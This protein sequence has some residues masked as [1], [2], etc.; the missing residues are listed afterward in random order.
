MIEKLNLLQKRDFSGVINAAFAFLSQEFKAYG[1]MFALFTGVPLLLMAGVTVWFINMMPQDMSAGEVPGAGFWWAFVF[2]GVLSFF[3][4]ALLFGTTGAYMSL[5]VQ[6]GAGNFQRRDV[7]SHFLQNL[8][9]MLGVLLLGGALFF[10]IALV[11]GVVVGFL[12]S[13]DALPWYI[14]V[15]LV[16]L[17]IGLMI[18]A[19]VPLSM[20]HMVVFH[21]KL[22][23]FQALARVFTLVRGAWW[24]TFGVLFVLSIIYSMLGFIFSIPTMAYPVIQELSGAGM[25]EPASFA[26]IALTVFSVLGRFVLYPILL[27]GVGVQYFSL[28]AGSDNDDLLRK[29]EAIG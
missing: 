1:A 10:A 28:K 23:A 3:V 9:R 29:V 2:L 15:F 27:V 13:A 16:F 4:F 19:W 14:I 12:A 25:V 21:E 22:S 8:G 7:W 5:Y 11:V 6:E 24:Q 26:F 17:F 18:Y 20:V